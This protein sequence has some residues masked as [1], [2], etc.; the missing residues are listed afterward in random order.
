[1]L[2]SNS[3]DQALKDLDAQNGAR[4]E[5]HL[6]LGP[7]LERQRQIRSDDIIY[8]TLPDFKKLT[9]DQM[10]STTASLSSLAVA[11]KYADKA[12]TLGEKADTERAYLRIREG[13]GSLPVNVAIP[14]QKLLKKMAAFYFKNEDP[15]RA[16]IYLLECAQLCNKTGIVDKEVWS[17]L[18]RVL[19][20]S[21]RE[22]DRGLEMVR[23]SESI[24]RVGQPAFP[25]CIGFFGVVAYLLRYLEWNPSQISQAHLPFMMLLPRTFLSRM[26]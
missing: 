24:V 13:Y 8:K 16:E 26:P 25:P 11:E 19:P 2:T 14:Y 1:V 20:E 4:E 21:S 17:D 18:A 9:A 23:N 22:L 6:T 15:R 5:L 12:A 3:L 7:H 10:S